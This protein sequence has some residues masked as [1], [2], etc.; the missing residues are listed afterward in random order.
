MQKD[1]HTH[2]SLLL[3]FYGP[4]LTD[5]QREYMDLYL[6]SDYSLGEIAEHYGVSRQAV[7]DSLVRAQAQLADVD[8]KLGLMKRFYVQ[9]ALLNEILNSAD[10]PVK[11]RN[12]VEQINALWEDDHGF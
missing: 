11:V 8:A 2:T 12:Y 1:P 5:R 7:R 3:D 10:D 9:K 4:F 6:N